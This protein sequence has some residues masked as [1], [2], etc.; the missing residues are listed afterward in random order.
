MNF[1]KIMFITMALVL[2]LSQGTCF[3][4]M[5]KSS[6]VN[7]KSSNLTKEISEEQYVQSLAKR[8]NISMIEA[9]A[10]NDAENIKFYETRKNVITRGATETIKYKTVYGYTGIAGAPL[11]Q[12]V[13]MAEVK[14]VYDIVAKKATQI[15]AVQSPYMYV[16]GASSCTVQGGDFVT[17]IGSTSAR[18]SRSANFVFVVSATS[19]VT[20]GLDII[21]IDKSATTTWTVTSKG[22]T[23]VKTIYLSELN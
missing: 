14:Y 2:I 22:R 5:L 17:N 11:N 16:S 9:K 20:V 7:L 8:M 4:E 23:Y 18:L 12:C 3:A 1:R 21:S 10:I 13:I 15:M 6:E 19:G